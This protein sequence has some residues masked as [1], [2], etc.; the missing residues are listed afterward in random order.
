MER[1]WKVLLIGGSSGVGKSTIARKFTEYYGIPLM[2]V[3]DIRIAL[4]QIVKQED[5][6]DLFTFI[7]NQGRLNTYTTHELVEKLIAVGNILTPVLKQIIKK[8]IIYN[9]PMVMEGDSILPELISLVSGPEVRSVFLYDDKENIEE[10][11][12][13]RSRGGILSEKNFDIEVML[14]FRYG[15]Y[16]KEQA[17][18]KNLNVIQV[19]PI[20]TV[21]E[22]ILR[23]ISVDNEKDYNSIKSFDE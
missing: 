16:I 20:E 5:H 14:S 7:K 4:Q 22:R 3:D 2:E 23:S 15:E 18:K 11:T 12:K 21:F 10:R 8:H 6:P 13:R 9:E 19:S 1:K 17:Q